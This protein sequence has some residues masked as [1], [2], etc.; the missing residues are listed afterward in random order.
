MKTLSSLNLKFSSLGLKE[1]RRSIAGWTDPYTGIMYDDYQ[2]GN[3]GGSVYNGGTLE[4]CIITAERGGG[5][6]PHD[7]AYWSAI[8]GGMGYDYGGGA[9]GG[10]GG[11]SA[12]GYSGSGYNDNGNYNN[13]PN[14]E[15]FDSNFSY[16]EQYAISKLVDSL[17]TELQKNLAFAL[18]DDITDPRF[19]HAGSK[20]YEDSNGQWTDHL[21]NYDTLVFKNF[22]QIKDN[23]WEEAFHQWQYHNYN[24]DSDSFI[25]HK[26]LLFMEMQTDIVEFLRHRVSGV[27]L[28]TLG[29]ESKFIKDMHDFFGDGKS[30][31]YVDYS[32][33][34]VEI[35]IIFSQLSQ[36]DW[37][38]IYDSWKDTNSYKLY[39]ENGKYDIDSAAL[40]TFS[41]FTAISMWFPP[42]TQH[43]SQCPINYGPYDNGNPYTYA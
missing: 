40:K 12:G 14:S 32:K 17:P 41:W 13:S 30:N 31:H 27:P 24:F 33:T 39:S 20:G 34:G 9:S 11:A 2:H 37:K 4:E 5:D 3:Q 38:S 22:D 10:D 16:A 7:A 29:N 36:D 1:M 25:S 8:Y 21:F 42:E 18:D 43:V 19:C 15:I 6:V 35:G 28:T 26:E 23:L